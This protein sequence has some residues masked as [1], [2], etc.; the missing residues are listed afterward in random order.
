MNLVSNVGKGTGHFIFFFYRSLYCDYDLKKKLLSELFIY[1][2]KNILIC[3]F[4]RRK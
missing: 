3:D 4:K 1:F 2:S